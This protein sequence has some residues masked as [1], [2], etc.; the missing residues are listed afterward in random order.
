MIFFSTISTQFET[1]DNGE[2]LSLATYVA[3]QLD[4]TFPSNGIDSDI[5]KIYLLLPNTI[6]RLKI[7]LQ[8][9]HCFDENSFNLYNSLQYTTFLYILANQQWK[10]GTD[11][12]LAER[13]FCLNRAL[14][15]PEE[16]IESLPP[17]WRQTRV[18]ACR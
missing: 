6:E 10:S 12:S 8:A 3:K 1:I 13:L 16:R 5:H 9:V 18:S 7:V 4:S 14:N 15:S 17:N 2:L 11:L